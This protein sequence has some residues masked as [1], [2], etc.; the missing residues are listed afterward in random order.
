MGISRGRQ[1]ACDAQ[2]A[3]GVSRDQNDQEEL[4]VKKISK[5]EIRNSKKLRTFS[6]VR[7]HDRFFKRSSQ[8]CRS[9]SLTPRF[10]EVPR[11]LGA[12]LTVSTVSPAAFS[13]FVIRICFEF[14]VSS[15]EFI[16]ACI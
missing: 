9:L 13:N 4:Q 12:G 11:R 7:L 6:A 3:V 5:S 10:S 2:R 1:S 16:S 15:F 8:K 14:R